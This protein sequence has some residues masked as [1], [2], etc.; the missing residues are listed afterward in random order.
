MD[1]GFDA[2]F[3]AKVALEALREDATVP[4]LLSLPA[5]CTAPKSGRA[6]RA[7]KEACFAKLPGKRL[8]TRD[9][10]AILFGYCV[11]GTRLG[12]QKQRGRRSSS[13]PRR[14]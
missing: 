6:R 12:R 7:R 2:A 10:E 8:P 1:P 5:T 14:T 11:L 9:A 4:E 13:G 3:K